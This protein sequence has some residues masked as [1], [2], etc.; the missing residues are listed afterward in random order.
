MQSAKTNVAPVAPNVNLSGEDLLRKAIEFTPEGHN[1]P[2]KVTPKNVI[3][4]LAVRSKSGAQPTTADAVVYITTCKSRGLNP[5][6]K[7]DVLLQGYDNWKKNKKTGKWDLLGTSWEVITCHP[8]YMKRNNAHP[9]FAGMESGV[10]YWDDETGKRMD[11]EGEILPPGKELAG[12]W[13]RVH[14]TDR[15]VQK[16]ASVNLSAYSEA[17]NRYVTDPHGMICK[18]AECKASRHAFPFPSATIEEISRETGMPVADLN[19]TLGE[20]DV[21]D[22]AAEIASRSADAAAV[23]GEID[24]DNRND[25]PEQ[26]VTDQSPGEAPPDIDW[27]WFADHLGTIMTEK[28]LDDLRNELIDLHPHQRQDIF[29]RCEE[30]REVIREAA[31][32]GAA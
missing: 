18:V 3:D 30:H 25:E 28:P 19:V 27:T 11:V 16:Y 17:G 12:G 23:A 2:I 13:A 22:A 20:R 15:A 32:G 31:K 10:V 9:A 21:A 26:D 29:D 6:D 4:I 24:G 1:S 7:K 5:W 8:A 14:R